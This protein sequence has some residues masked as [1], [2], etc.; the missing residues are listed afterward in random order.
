LPPL[1]LVESVAGKAERE[2]EPQPFI[3]A[4]ARG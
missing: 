1:D 3:P 2:E 4:H